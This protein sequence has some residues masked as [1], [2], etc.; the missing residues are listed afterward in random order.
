MF[1][2]FRCGTV[3]IRRANW[4]RGR[5]P[6]KG[7]PIGRTKYG[8][9]GLTL[10]KER[11]SQASEPPALGVDCN[12]APARMLANSGEHFRYAERFGHIG[13]RADAN[14]TRFPCI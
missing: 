7:R 5:I 9:A 4:I 1:L 12:Q 11:F 13:V 14:C 3:L 10:T 6:K 2:F 8:S